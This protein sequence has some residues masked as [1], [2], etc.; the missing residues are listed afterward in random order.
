MD[1]DGC[2]VT[3]RDHMLRRVTGGEWEARALGSPRPVMVQFWR[4]TCPNCRAIERPLDALASELAGR[5][6]MYRVDCDSEEDLVWA[7]EV[8]STPTFVVFCRGEPA[9][10]AYADASVAELR[11]MALDAFESCREG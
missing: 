3:E 5:V 10:R 9:S 1:I 7:Y 4:S 11:S 8:M 2:K 6:E